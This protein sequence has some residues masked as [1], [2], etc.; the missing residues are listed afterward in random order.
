MNY[1]EQYYK[2]LCEQLQSQINLIEKQIDDAQVTNPADLSP[3]EQRQQRVSTQV[4]NYAKRRGQSTTPVDYGS[5]GPVMTRDGKPL[6]KETVKNVYTGDKFAISHSTQGVPDQ[7]E[8]GPA[9]GPSQDYEPVSTGEDAEAEYK[10]VQA[11]KAKAL[12]GLKEHRNLEQYYRNLYEQLQSQINLIEKRFDISKFKKSKKGDKKDDKKSGKKAD[13]KSDK[14]YDGDGEVES[15]KD[16]YFGSKD[17]AIKKS[18][19]DKKKKKNLKEGREISGGQFTYGGF[20]KIF[21]K[22]TPDAAPTD[23][24]GDGDADVE[25]VVMR[26]RDG[27]M[28]PSVEYARVAQASDTAGQAA[29]A[30][31]AAALK[32]HQNAAKEWGA[33]YDNAPAFNRALGNSGRRRAGFADRGKHM[34]ELPY[35]MLRDPEMREL[36][37]TIETARSASDAA[38]QARRSHPH[39]EEFMK[40]AQATSDSVHGTRGNL[41]S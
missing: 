35:R 39:H 6:G 14:D 21:L 28:Y 38:Y 12:Q 40:R 13:K 19:A 34:A 29:S 5:E 36:R 4:H 10:R 18:I 1:L 15:S 32:F 20:P 26:A 23:V 22:E 2:N 30:A 27:T 37:A 16:E 8:I 41:G 17:K 11:S 3:E 7:E 31:E 9:D 24:D 25:D 33:I